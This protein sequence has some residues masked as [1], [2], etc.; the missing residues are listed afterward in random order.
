MSADGNINIE[1]EG[2]IFD[3][4][5]MLRN[6]FQGIE[7]RI[8]DVEK[9]GKKGFDGI[10][11]AM[12]MLNFNAIT[13]GL[14]NISDSLSFTSELGTL[15]NDIARLTDASGQ[16]LDDLTRSAYRLG[17]VWDEDAEQIAKAANTMTKTIGGSFE[18]NM[19]LIE[20]GFSKGANA[21]GDM[22]R[23]LEEY[24]PFVKQLGLDASETIAF[25]ASATK[26]GVFDD[27]AMDS[28]KEA[29]LSL[30][31]MGQAQIEALN[32]IGIKSTDLV[33][34]TTMESVKM[35]ST[36]MKTADTQARQL[37]LADIFK[38]AGED[39][40]LAFIE[41]LDT[42]DLSIDNLPSVNTF[43][44]SFNSWIADMKVSIFE[45]AGDTAAYLQPITDLT[46]TFSTFMPVLSGVGSAMS[47]LG[48]K[49]KITS[50][51]T[52]AAETVQWLWNAALTAN[53]IGA[54]VAAIGVITLSV[55]GLTAAFSD[56]T[57]MQR[58]N[59]EITKDLNVAMV[60]EEVKLKKVFDQLRTTNPETEERKKLIT[61]LQNQYPG[62]LDKY[63]LEKA[64]LED[65]DRLQKQATNSARARIL[66]QLNEDKATQLL[67]EAAEIRGGTMWS[68]NTWSQ[69][70]RDEEAAQKEKEADVLLQKNFYENEKLKRRS[71]AFG[72]DPTDPT[73]VEP[74]DNVLT[75]DGNLKN[76]FGSKASTQKQM[77]SLVV[78]IDNLVNTLNITQSN[79]SETVTTIKNMVSEALVGAVKDFEV[80]M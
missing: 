24:G 47:W 50:T 29:N 14:G 58:I 69:G 80:S 19:T 27:K 77:K 46:R 52:K 66:Q 31:E 5:K 12:K 25:I 10:G 75:G 51:I 41:G 4:L 54:V 40:G 21:N 72:V 63:D 8:E 38:G 17:E 55:I 32:G 68:T 73:T 57:D 42:M 33:G 9:A 22:L 56:N 65:I 18:E 79:R 61:E 16:E 13:E 3:A 15:K 6:D 67:K 45:F 26:D 1:L 35:I 20:Q 60:D 11:K 23:Q 37:V 44:S 76:V 53:P 70:Q 48:E 59:T 34:K 71:S 64:S 2:A 28:M 62:L 36:A 78:N 43:G 7:G 30:R 39:A 49:T 74:T